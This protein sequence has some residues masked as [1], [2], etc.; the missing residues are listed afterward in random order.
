MLLTLGLLSK[1]CRQN[2][3]S[4]DPKHGR[5]QERHS[6]GAAAEPVGIQL[7]SAQDVAARSDC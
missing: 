4:M 5:C 7:E 6:P 2:K 1:S 3:I